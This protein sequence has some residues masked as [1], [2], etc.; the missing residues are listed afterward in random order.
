MTHITHCM[1]M[2][3]ALLILFVFGHLHTTHITHCMNMVNALLILFVFGHLHTTHITHYMNIVNAL[4]ILILF[5]FVFQFLFIT[6]HQT[7]ILT[8][9]YIP[10]RSRYQ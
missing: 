2:V 4:L 9:L 7:Y 8:M 3:N 10:L 6:L 1:N 5:V